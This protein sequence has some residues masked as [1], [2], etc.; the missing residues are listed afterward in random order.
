MIF[1]CII[2]QSFDEPENIEVN[3]LLPNNLPT[4]KIK[5][6]I[7]IRTKNDK[8]S[9]GNKINIIFN[10]MFLNFKPINL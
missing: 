4:E 3:I 2:S 9:Y 6:N 5:G 10:S 1:N 8:V 7:E